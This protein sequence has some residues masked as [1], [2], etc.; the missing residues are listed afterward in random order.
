ME[1]VVV[2]VGAA[3]VNGSPRLEADPRPR[4][5]PLKTNDLVFF[6]EHLFKRY[7]GD[8]HTTP[9]WVYEMGP[10]LPILDPG[11]VKAAI[12]RGV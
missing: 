4:C 6:T 5:P 1:S 3:S 9:V 10:L 12:S 11:V 7:L 8:T 2:V